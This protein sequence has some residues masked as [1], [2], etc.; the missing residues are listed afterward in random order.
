MATAKKEE[1]A[2]I[3]KDTVDV[4]ADKVRKFQESG[5]LH[6][7]ADYSPENAMKAAW[8]TLQETVD[9]DDKPALE[10][11]T[12]NSIA[13]ALLNMVVQGLNPMKKQCY[14]IVYGNKLTLQRSYFGTMH[15][16]K[17]V[18]PEIETIVA[19][20]VYQDDVFEF[21]KI[22]GCTEITKHVSKLQNMDP[23]KIIAAYCSIFWRNGK[24]ESTIMTIDEI[25]QSWRQS[26]TNPVL[27]DGKLKEGST[28]A[29]FTAEMAKRT[30]VNRACKAIINSS[31]DST[32]LIK[33]FHASDADLAEA[34]AQ[35]EIHDNAN[36]VYVDTKEINEET[37]EVLT[38]D[39]PLAPAP[40]LSA[41]QE[42]DLP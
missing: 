21:A 12:R 3:K 9:K 19:D 11:C 7:P 39:G 4:V 15:I 41:P 25:K 17:T 24:E 37:G 23:K 14:Y 38:D 34:E 32:L 27:A 26:K 5:E 42:D 13:N 6:F 16:A 10:V 36:T 33:A 35:E 28:H 22:R 20:V 29:K 30:V 40:F 1:L 8:L 18:D 2:L 31:S